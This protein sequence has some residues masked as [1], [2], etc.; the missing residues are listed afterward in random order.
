MRLEKILVYSI[1]RK[2]HIISWSGKDDFYKFIVIIYKPRNITNKNA[3][4]GA[5]DTNKIH[6][7]V[8]HAE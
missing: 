5:V 7:F 3:I 8:I 2:R 4:N 6:R 1:F